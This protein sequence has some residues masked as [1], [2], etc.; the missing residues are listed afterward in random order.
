M[1]KKRIATLL[2]S[3]FSAGKPFFRKLGAAAAMCCIPCRCLV[4]ACPRVMQ[5][6]LRAPAARVLLGT[7]GAGINA[8]KNR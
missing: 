7:A 6:I 3:T 8:M 2:G 1:K 4:G 5:G